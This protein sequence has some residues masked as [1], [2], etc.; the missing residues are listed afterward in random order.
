MDLEIIGQT[1]LDLLPVLALR[2]VGLVLLGLA[3]ALAAC[4]V[5]ALGCQ[6]VDR[7]RRG[8]M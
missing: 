1:A 3:I 7:R 8:T 4:A 5:G 6:E 2:V